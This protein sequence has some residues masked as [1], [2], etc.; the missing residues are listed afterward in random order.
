M[1]GRLDSSENS[2]DRQ[3]TSLKAVIGEAYREPVARSEYVVRP[4]P[5]V[6]EV[7]LVSACKKVT[8]PVTVTHRD[9]LQKFMT[10]GFGKRSPSVPR[11]D[12][13]VLATPRAKTRDL[14]GTEEEAS[15]RE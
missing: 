14:V 6:V 15:C 1:I 7:L 2:M 12:S 4:G 9:T 13:L 11:G 10:T 3:R 8:W 5:K